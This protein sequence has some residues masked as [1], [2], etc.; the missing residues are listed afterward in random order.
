M[1]KKNLIKCLQWHL[2]LPKHSLQLLFIWMKFNK[3]L[4]GRKRKRKEPVEQQDLIL[5]NLGKLSQ[6]TRRRYWKNRIEWQLSLALTSLGTWIKNSWNHLLKRNFISHSRT[7]RQ[8]RRY[9]SILC[10]KK[11]LSYLTTSQW[12]QS[13]MLHKDTQGATYIYYNLV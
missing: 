2:M 3:Y 8:E 12:Q 13:L 9:L 4:K 1:I 10:K 7:M 6:N 5:R 11:E